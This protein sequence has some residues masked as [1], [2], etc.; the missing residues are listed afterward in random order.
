MSLIKSLS[1]LV[2]NAVA[3][4]INVAKETKLLNEIMIYDDNHDIKILTDLINE[5][6]IF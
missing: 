2:H 5:F 6:F 3:N 1:T 4:Q